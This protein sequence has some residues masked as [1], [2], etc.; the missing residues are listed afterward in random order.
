MKN[1]VTAVLALVGGFALSFLGLGVLW[2][3]TPW[4]YQALMLFPFLWLAFAI[5]RAGSA[6]DR[7]FVLILVGAAPIGGVMTMFRDR[8]GSH[9]GSILVVCAWLAG[10][11]AGQQL[12][13][14]R[15]RMP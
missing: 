13:A 11:L 10:V 7:V 8:N 15:T 12:A 6:G 5:T 4:P 2:I 3:G 9:L 1:L 14:R